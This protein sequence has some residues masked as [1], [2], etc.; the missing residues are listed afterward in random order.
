MSAS[1]KSHSQGQTLVLTISN[2]EHH[3]ALDATVCAAAVEALGVAESSAEIR[4]VVITGE[5]LHFCAGLQLKTLNDERHLGA[6]HNLQAI[7]SHH[8]WIEAIRTFPKP[9]VAAVEGACAATGFS[10]ALACD[11][12]VASHNSVFVMSH[13]TV[14]LSPDGGATHH[15]LAAMPRATAAQL[16]MMGERV[17]AERLHQW[18]VVNHLSNPGE[19]LS[20]ALALCERL[21]ARAPQ[22]LASIKELINE[23][24][25]QSLHAQLRL[26][27]DHFVRNLLHPHAGEGL[28]AFLEKRPA[29]FI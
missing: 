13:S 25:G 14:G 22:A 10:L 15:L 16:L 1:L 6:E 28:Q 3:N 7:E 8:N 21:N 20:D 26:E 29:Q 17:N 9:V 24:P 11:L 19:A 27:R 18:G 2:P 4:S 23:A 12:M 5:G